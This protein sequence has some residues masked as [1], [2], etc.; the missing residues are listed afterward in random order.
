MTAY[1]SVISIYSANQ[2]ETALKWLNQRENLKDDDYQILHSQ[3]VEGWSKGD[4]PGS[5]AYVG[6][7]PDGPVRAGAI[8][9]VL[10][11]TMA[12][13]STESATDSEQQIAALEQTQRWAGH[14][15]VLLR[16]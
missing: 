15:E 16:L 6:Q 10:S 13:Y 4:L 1:R 11:A 2:P 14:R 7:L 9:S 3:L 8:A 5:K 12:G